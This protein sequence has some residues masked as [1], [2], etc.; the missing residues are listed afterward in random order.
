M[1]RVFSLSEALLDRILLSVLVSLSAEEPDWY[2]TLALVS[3]GIQKSIDRLLEE[4]SVVE[5]VRHT[6]L[7][8]RSCVQLRSASCGMSEDRRSSVIRVAF[9]SC[10]GL[11]NER[12]STSRRKLCL[13]H[14][15]RAACL[16]AAHLLGLQTG[17]VPWPCARRP[18]Q[19][20]KNPC[21]ARATGPQL[22]RALQVCETP[23]NHRGFLTKAVGLL[24][25]V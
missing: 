3:K 9:G 4:P 6:S 19:L 8:E 17:Y 5:Q 7:K 20:H 2:S 22:F 16:G 12:S 11:K 10:L 18:H 24:R 15:E 23:G 14:T 25:A 13:G 1:A 21:E